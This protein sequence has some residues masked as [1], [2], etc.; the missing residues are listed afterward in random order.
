MNKRASHNKIGELP[1]EIGFMR[2]VHLLELSNNELES[3]PDAM[4]EMLHLEQLYLQRNKLKQLPNLKNCC[5]LK[6]LLVGNNQIV[7]LHFPFAKKLNVIGLARIPFSKAPYLTF[8]QV[9]N[10]SLM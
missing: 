3:T 9:N 7:W 6:E 5:H 2:S 1:S 4:E 8:L 10:N